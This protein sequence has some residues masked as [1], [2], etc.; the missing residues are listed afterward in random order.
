VSRLRILLCW[1]PT[2]ENSWNPDLIDFLRAAGDEVV[3]VHDLAGLDAQDLSGFDACLPRFRMGSAEMVCLD[4]RLVDSGIPMINSQR[5]RRTCE[6][7]AL[8]HL[9]FSGLA[10]PQPRSF[11]ISEEGLA[12]RDLVWAGETIVKPLSGNRGA[13]TQIVPTLEEAV[14]LARDRREDLLIQEMIWPARCWRL[15]VGRRSG[16]ADAYWRRPASPGD[17]ILSISTGA[18]IVRDPPSEALREVST[19]MLAAVDG[20]ILAVD[21]L[22][23]ETGAAFALEINHN[24]DA[25]GGT[26]QAATAFRRE[27]T[28]VSDLLA[29]S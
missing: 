24:F 2:E 19:A 1:S 4:E 11:V 16:I 26:P 22:E 3:E 20:H 8:A 23:T 5:C 7:K 18:E 14:A 29:V 28:A 6:N 10:I 12:D 15:I 13:G 27:V 17:R 21:V 25:H 9:A